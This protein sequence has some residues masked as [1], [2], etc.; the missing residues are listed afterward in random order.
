MGT[1]THTNTSTNDPTRDLGCVLWQDGDLG[2]G[3]HHTKYRCTF[4][5]QVSDSKPYM[6]QGA[7][8]NTNLKKRR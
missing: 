4:D 5:S 3:H 8:A 2:Q 7:H 1:K 6:S